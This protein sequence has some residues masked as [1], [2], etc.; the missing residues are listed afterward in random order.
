[1]PSTTRSNRSRPPGS[2]PSPGKATSPPAA[3]TDAPSWNLEQMTLPGLGSGTSSPASEDGHGPCDSPGSLTTPTSGPPPARA[4]H[5]PMQGRGKEFATLDIFGQHSS[6]SSS[7][8]ALQSSLV[9]RLR[10]GLASRGSTLFTLT[11][12][13]AVTPSGRRIS[14]LRALGRRTSDSDSSS[15]PTPTRQDSASSGARDYEPSE[16]HHAG[17][18]LTDAAR[19]ASWPTPRA[20]DGSKGTRS[21]IGAELERRRTQGGIDLPATAKAA[22]WPTPKKN[23]TDRGGG[24]AH[25]DGRRSNLSDTVH[26]AAWTTPMARD[27]KDSAPTSDTPTNALLGRQVQLTSWS[28]PTA[29]RSDWG[30]DGKTGEKIMHLGGE[31]RLASWA[32]PAAH[33]PGGT[34]EQAIARKEKA[35][36]T[37][38][39]MGASVTALSHQVQLTGPSATGSPAR[40]E[41][42]GQLNPAHS[43]WLMGYPVAWD[44]CGATVTRSSRKSRPSSSEPPSKRS[45]RKKK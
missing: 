2:K 3:S 9:S 39:Q 26:T 34:P 18:T 31:A 14:Q 35:Q 1:M 40:T 17:T 16:T 6:H 43:R 42:R 29:S 13:D 36:A 27:H 28:T 25:M 15:W 21:D 38:I 10:Q 5:S 30:Y 41:S 24:V 44:S 4:N 19:M 33:E 11:W 23:D 12:R 22:A 8:A 20:E 32:T 45:A 7:S 37:G